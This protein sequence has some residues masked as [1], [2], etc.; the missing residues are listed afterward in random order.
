[1]SLDIGIDLGTANIIVYLSGRGIVLVE[2]SVVA[3]D[4]KNNIIAIGDAAKIMI[5]RTPHNIKVIRPLRGGVISDF[6][7]TREMIKYFIKKVIG[8][9]L[10]KIKPRIAICVPSRVTEVE[11][12]AVEDVARQ[13]GAR[14]VKVIE[15]PIAAAIGSGIDITKPMGT[16]V[17]DIG[18]GTT[19]V[20]IISLGG[21]VVSESV[22]IAGDTINESIINYIKRE[23][24]ILIG[25]RTAEIIKIEIGNAHHTIEEK[26]LEVSG[27]DLIQGLPKKAFIKSSEIRKCMRE[28]LLGMIECC[29]RVLERTPPELISDIVDRGIILTGGG[30]LIPGLDL[31]LHDELQVE[32]LVAEES[33]YCVAIGTGK[34]LEYVVNHPKNKML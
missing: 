13:V 28:N 33:L 2:P 31:L 17:V 32:A 11:K 30:S 5:G 10:F 9:H 34:Y 19:D 26:Y 21:T 24:Q 1:M 25:E 6:V 15:E 20:A 29:K 22:K 7:I 4:E 8:V 23:K 3:V 12:R 14:F 18:G 16:M 27:R